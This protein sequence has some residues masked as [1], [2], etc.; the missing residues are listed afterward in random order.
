MGAITEAIKDQFEHDRQNRMTQAAMMEKY[1]IPASYINRLLSG[2]R[3]Y[4]G[5]SVALVERMFPHAHILLTADSTA[6]SEIAARL[7]YEILNAFNKIE[8]PN[9]L[10]GELCKAVLTVC[11]GERKD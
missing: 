8:M 7:G 3:E 11:A 6:A 1:G 4:S 10:R 5:L 9:E 2:K